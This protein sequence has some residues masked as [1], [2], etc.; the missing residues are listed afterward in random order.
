MSTSRSVSGEL[1]LAVADQD[2]GKIHSLLK[3]IAMGHENAIAVIVEL[4]A[5][6]AALA[7]LARGPEWRDQMNFAILATQIDTHLGGTAG[8]EQ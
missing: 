5:A 2:P 4:A 7:E 1:I 8:E 6:C 3:E